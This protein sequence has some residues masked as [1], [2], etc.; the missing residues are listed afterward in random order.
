MI[1]IYIGQ[2]N[3]KIKR[4][5]QIVPEVYGTT[6]NGARERKDFNQNQYVS[7][8]LFWSELTLGVVFHNGHFL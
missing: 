3:K 5:D 1:N 7:M 8:G 4:A 2:K 6:L